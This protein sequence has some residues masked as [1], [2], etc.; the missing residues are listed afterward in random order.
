MDIK[1][2]AVIGSG[3]MGSGIAQ[4]AAQY[5]Y[6]IILEDVKREFVMAGLENIRKRLDKRVEEG[7]LR[8]EEEA[9]I[10][11][12]IRTST[13][14]EEC[15]DADLIIEAAVEREEIKKTIFRDLDSFCRDETIFASNTSSIPIARLAQATK[16]PDR[17]AGMHF[18]NPA[19]VMKLVE[20]IRGPHSS[21]DTIKATMVFS[22]SIGKTPVVVNDSPGFV[23]SR[24]LAAM[25]NDAVYCLQEGVATREGIDT[26]MKLG[27]NHPM[28]PFELAD[29]MGLDV[30]LEILRI[31]HS[32]LG[33]RYRP[34]P[35]LIDMVAAGRF[36]RKN[37]EGFYEY[38]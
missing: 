28:G 2:I 18:M 36:G 24:V 20:I 31:L 37:G 19:Y 5:G 27:A 1:T 29:L 7:K 12:R 15:C 13:L 14:L 11:S 38:K 3:V 9:L 23:I 21:E 22:E 33:E 4:T 10:L 8:Q 32:D 26:I 25:I 16:R 34:C 6:D 35:V 30:C 17:F